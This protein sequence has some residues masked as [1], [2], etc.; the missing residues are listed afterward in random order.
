MQEASFYE[1]ENNIVKCTLC[2]HFCKILDGKSGSCRVRKNMDGKLISENY[3][4]VCSLHFDPI[5]KKPLYHYYPGQT[6][7]SVGSVGCNLHCK[8][9]QNWEIS[10]TGVDAS[11]RL[12]KIPPE[13]IIEMALNQDGN[14]GI[15]YTYNEPTVWYEYMLDIAKQAQAKGLKNVMVTNGFINPGPLNELIKYM[16]AFSVDLKAFTND[17]YKDLTSSRIEPVK[18]TIKQIKSSGKHLEIT[19]LVITNRNDRQKDFVKMIDW[20]AKET[21]KD[22]VLHISKYF[23]TYKMMDIATPD[24]TLLN[25]YKLARKKLNYV[26]LGN[27]RSE[28]GQNTHCSKCKATVIERTGYTTTIKG[29]D[30]NGQCKKCNYPVISKNCI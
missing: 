18:E 27:M 12:K 2:P 10:Q 3:G 28:E 20:I 26:Y 4:Q 5:E 17:F 8:F 14:M 13:H 19:N 11:F 30:E 22:T 1:S 23:P 6:I 15:A 25:F 7:L 9:C 29:L 21:G 24:E 16:D